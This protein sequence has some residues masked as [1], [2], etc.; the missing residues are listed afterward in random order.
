VKKNPFRKIN[1]LLGK[2]PFG[3]RGKKTHLERKKLD[4]STFKGKRAF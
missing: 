4:I 3:K 1:T 2:D